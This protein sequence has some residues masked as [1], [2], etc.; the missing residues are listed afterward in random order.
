MT[1]DT[2]VFNAVRLDPITGEKEWIGR[3]GTRTAIARDGLVVD[4]TS[5]GY[6][7]HEWLEASGYVDLDLVRKFPHGIAV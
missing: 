1:N 5:L 7:P 3:M 2:A 4:P 6:C